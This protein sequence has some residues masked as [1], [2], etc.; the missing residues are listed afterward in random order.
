M[1]DVAAELPI[2]PVAPDIAAPSDEESAEAETGA[3]FD[4]RVSTPES[5]GPVRRAILE[6]LLD[7]AESG[8]QTVAQIIAGL[9]NVSRGSVES[10]VLRNLRAG[11]IER[12]A[13][14]TYR[15]APPPKPKPPEPPPPTPVDDQLWFEALERWAIDP[16]S[17]PEEL[18]PRPDQRPNRIPP[19]VAIRFNDRVRKREPRRRDAEAAAAKRVA[20][21]AQLRAKLAEA[22]HGN[23]VMG[24][25]IE[26]VRAVQAALELVSL[27]RV[28][29]AVRSVT[30]R[31]IFPKN[32]PAR[33]WSEPRLLKKIAEDFCRFDVVPRLVENW[34]AAGTAPQKPAG[35]SEPSPAVEVPPES[36]PAVW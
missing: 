36:A 7:T 16:S 12:V 20:D 10:A 14:G 25:G 32:E 31:R 23:I 34:K 15:L 9:G 18:G 27:E 11:L 19:D 6:H 33:A 3:S 22:C 28:L 4:P 8:E 5:I 17:W 2:D 35:A 29:Q 21:D 13:P 24:A 26:D 1:T 30:D